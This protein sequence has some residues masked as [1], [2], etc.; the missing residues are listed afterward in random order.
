MICRLA[1]GAR[2]AVVVLLLVTAQPGR[3]VLCFAA[4]HAELEDAFALGGGGVGSVPPQTSFVGFSSFL[5]GSG[6]GG[7]ARPFW[8]CP[9]AAGPRKENVEP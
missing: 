2:W 8:F 7:A 9:P 5:S 4:D 6:E 1:G 3:F